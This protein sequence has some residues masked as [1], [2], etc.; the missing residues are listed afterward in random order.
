MNEETR[1]KLIPLIGEAE[2]AADAVQDGSWRHRSN[3]KAIAL[4]KGSSASLFSVVRDAGPRALDGKR[5]R[6]GPNRGFRRYCSACLY[7]AICAELLDYGLWDD[8]SN[9]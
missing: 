1:Q 8:Y 9:E 4:F 5:F 3:G 7:A 2:R 6:C